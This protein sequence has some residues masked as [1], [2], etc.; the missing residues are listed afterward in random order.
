MSLVRT[1][2]ELYAIITIH[3]CA[4]RIEFIIRVV[5]VSILKVLVSSKK[6]LKYNKI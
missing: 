3:S 5:S 2:V 1:E 4:N 6:I